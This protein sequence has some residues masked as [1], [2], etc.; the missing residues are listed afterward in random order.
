[1]D[2]NTFWAFTT[3]EQCTTWPGHSGE[4]SISNGHCVAGAGFSIDQRI[5]CDCTGTIT[6]KVAFRDFCTVENPAKMCALVTNYNGC[7][8]DKTKTVD[9]WLKFYKLSIINYYY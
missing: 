8:W 9:K 1:M 5:T 2:S 3:P 7:P 6:T 4:N